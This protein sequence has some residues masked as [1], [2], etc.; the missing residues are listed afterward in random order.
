M[1]RGRRE[2]RVGKLG[3]ERREEEILPGLRKEKGRKE[4]G[5]EEK[6][7]RSVN[8]SYCCRGKFPCAEVWCSA[9]RLW[10]EMD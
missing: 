2:D 5:R 7:K 9:D 1:K 3:C 6:R 8:E 4:E 10:K